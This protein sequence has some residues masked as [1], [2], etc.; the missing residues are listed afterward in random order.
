METEP[1]SNP[2]LEVQKSLAIQET[3]LYKIQVMVTKKMS[4]F[5]MISP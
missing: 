1:E 5:F 4:S 3:A 2:I